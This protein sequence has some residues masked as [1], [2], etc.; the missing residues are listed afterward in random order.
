MSDPIEEMIRKQGE[1]LPVPASLASRVR[2]HRGRMRLLASG[3]V[4]CGLFGWGIIAMPRTSE[5]KELIQKAIRGVRDAKVMQM[6]H[7][8][9]LEGQEPKLIGRHWIA[10]GR[11][12]YELLREGMEQSSEYTSDSGRCY[13]PRFDVLQ[14]FKY[15]RQADAMPRPS[16]NP[17]AAEMIKFTF[18]DGVGT[19]KREPLDVK[20][21]VIWHGVR[22][23]RLTF[24]VQGSDMEA[25]LYI[26]ESTG[27]PETLLRT[28]RSHFQGKEPR[29][30]HER[31]EFAYDTKAPNPMDRVGP[32]TKRFDMAEW[33][34]RL[35][36][37]PYADSP[38]GKVSWAWRGPQR[39]LFLITVGQPREWVAYKGV[40]WKMTWEVFPLTATGDFSAPNHTPDPRMVV[41]TPLS[42]RQHWDLPFP[43]APG[44]DYPDEVFGSVKANRLLLTAEGCARV[45]NTELRNRG[46]EK[47]EWE[48]LQMS[49]RERVKVPIF[50]KDRLQ[51]RYAELSKKY[52]R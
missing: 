13:T 42:T 28:T 5:A 40:D 49:M 36:Q 33:A 52:S 48:D 47:A 44:K 45:R 21:G 18:I 25:T 10:N 37:K 22:T 41:Y 34:V 6:N 38:F 1:S 32:K 31:T 7:Y 20:K 11:H 30:V 50:A 3:A 14:V 8:T 26:N 43:L 19:S 23:T 24:G 15:S 29:T 9:W 2:R 39:S 27:R 16:E 4:V 12:A 35:A 51:E 17:T 46:D